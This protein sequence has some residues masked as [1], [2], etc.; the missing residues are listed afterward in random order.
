[1]ILTGDPRRWMSEPGMAGVVH[2][3]NPYHGIQRGWDSAAQA[4]AMLE[5]TIQL[6]GPN[7]IAA[8]FLEPVIGTNGVLIPPDG[9]LEGVRELCNEVRNSDGGR[10]SHVG[11]RA[12]RASGSPSTTGASCPI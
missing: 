12:D 1:M 3:L 10:R 2:V 9:Y 8:F 6:E 4:L 11:L 5:E 7:T